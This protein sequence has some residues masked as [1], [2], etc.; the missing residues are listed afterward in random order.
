MLQIKNNIIFLTKGDEGVLPV[1]VTIEDGTAYELGEGEFLTLSVRSLPSADSPLL[2]RA[3]SNPGS[4]RI[5]IPAEATAE[6]EPGRYSADIQLT[7]SA[8]R[9]RTIWPD[10]T[11]VKPSSQ[12]SFD[13]FYLTP[14]VTV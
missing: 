2:M 10:N 6:M 7:D 1:D 9:P 11:E 3:Q 8:G 13:N 14:E 4:N 12:K 5:I